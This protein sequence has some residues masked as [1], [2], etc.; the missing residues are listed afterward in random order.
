MRDVRGIPI[1][2]VKESSLF[3]MY[4]IKGDSGQL[5]QTGSCQDY[6]NRHD[7]TAQFAYARS[8]GKG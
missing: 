6:W 3:D 1:A 4:A 7:V 5:V 8:Q 2:V